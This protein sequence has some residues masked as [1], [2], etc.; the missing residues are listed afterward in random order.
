M[1]ENTVDLLTET[2]GIESFLEIGTTKGKGNQIITIHQKKIRGS[3]E[4]SSCHC[5]IEIVFGSFL[6]LN[7]KVYR[8]Q[9]AWHVIELKCGVKNNQ[10]NRS[11]K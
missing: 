8:L 7:C 4:N 2:V 3:F 6:I 11:I 5:S 1:A 10:K 9:N